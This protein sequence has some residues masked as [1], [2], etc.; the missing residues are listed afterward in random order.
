MP[1]RAFWA[2]WCG[3]LSL[4]ETLFYLGYLSAVVSW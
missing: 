3:G 4:G 2:W 1:G